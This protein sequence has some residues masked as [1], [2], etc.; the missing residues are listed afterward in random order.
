MSSVSKVDL[1]M[2]C[3]WLA[4]SPKVPLPFRHLASRCNDNHCCQSVRVLRRKR[5]S[6]GITKIMLASVSEALRIQYDCLLKISREYV[7]QRHPE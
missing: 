2:V 4:D 7:P 5:H 6:L 1:S 3:R